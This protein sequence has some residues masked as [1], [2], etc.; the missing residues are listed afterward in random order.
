MGT[1][2]HDCI[3]YLHIYQ[4]SNLM[5]WLISI[6]IFSIS[7]IFTFS[8]PKGGVSSHMID[9]VGPINVAKSTHE[10]KITEKLCA[11]VRAGVHARMP[12]CSAMSNS[13]IPWTAALQAPLSMG[14]FRQEYWCGLPFPPPGDLP[15][16]GTKTHISCVYCIRRSILYPWAIWEAP[17]IQM[18]HQNPL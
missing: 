11:C 17:E 7:P 6:I 5:F 9:E 3:C 15:N 1:T 2:F 13:A 18:H 4:T 8:W 12:S 16:P 14:F 10:A